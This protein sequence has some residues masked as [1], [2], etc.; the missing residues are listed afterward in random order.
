M[1]EDTDT[2]RRLHIEVATMERWV[3][4]GWIAPRAPQAP[5][6]TE[7]DLARACLIRD[8]RE[9]MGVNEE[10]VGVALGLLDQ[11]HGLRHALRRVAAAVHGLPEPARQEILVVLREL[12]EGPT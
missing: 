8:L 4:A 12:D 2:L 11:I 1:A 6:Y 9:A 10:G 7:A 5:G 3:A